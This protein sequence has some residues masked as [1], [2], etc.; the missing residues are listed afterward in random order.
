M[1]LLLLSV[2]FPLIITVV[3]LRRNFGFWA[4]LDLWG[5]HGPL[6]LEQMHLALWDAHELLRCGKCG[7][8]WTKVV[9][10]SGKVRTIDLHYW[11]DWIYLGD[12]PFDSSVRVFSET[13]TERTFREYEY[14]HPVGRE[15]SLN[16]KIKERNWG[17]EQNSCLCFLTSFITH[18]FH[19]LLSM[20]SAFLNYEQ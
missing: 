16:K 2:F 10:L 18:C 14:S 6:Q 1:L 15:P 20:A 19:G 3:F 13:V 8:L 11:L 7:M 5:C 17:E 9:C 4:V 12:T